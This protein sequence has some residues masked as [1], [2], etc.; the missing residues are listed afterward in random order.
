MRN[1]PVKTVA[2]CM[3]ALCIPAMAHAHP[4]HDAVASLAVGLA[5]PFTGID[6]LL[7]LVATGLLARRMGTGAGIAIVMSFLLLLTAGAVYGISV[8]PMPGSEL[9]VYASVIVLAGLALKPARRFPLAVA[10]LAG[11]F[12]FFHGH[13]HGSEAVPGGSAAAYVAGILASSALICLATAAVDRVRV[14]ADRSGVG[15]ATR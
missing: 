12:A 14:L 3:A 10:A 8:L 9:V 6:H 2:T 4:G 11:A 5:H 15:R 1:T 13:A 7:A